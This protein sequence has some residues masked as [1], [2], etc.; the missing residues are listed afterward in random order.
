MYIENC[1]D[2]IC[3]CVLCTTFFGDVYKL[4]STNGFPTFVATC[5]LFPGATQLP[6]QSFFR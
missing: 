5:A 2:E 3:I 6:L 1:V 4:A